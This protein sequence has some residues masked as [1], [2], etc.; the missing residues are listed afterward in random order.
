MAEIVTAAS[1][2]LDGQLHLW[3]EVGWVEVFENNH[4]VTNRTPGD[5]VCTGLLNMDMPL[6]RYR[7]GDCGALEPWGVP[8]TCGR[9]LPTLASLEGRRDDILYTKDGRRIGRLD[10]IFKSNLR[11][12]EGQIIQETLDRVRIRY[13]PAPDFTTGTALLMVERLQERMGDVEVVLQQVDKIPR[14][15]NG[16]FRS[17]IC[18]LPKKEKENLMQMNRSTTPC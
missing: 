5:L 4:P 7:V 15:R 11:L 2:C 9:G 3:P 13:V 18:L 14:E 16:K 8:C 17:V 10:P 1:E 6:I 12:R